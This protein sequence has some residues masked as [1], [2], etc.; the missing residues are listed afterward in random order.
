MLLLDILA[1][2]TIG[3]LWLFI[4]LMVI[5]GFSTGGYLYY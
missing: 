2:V 5:N 1:Y 3:Y 4:L